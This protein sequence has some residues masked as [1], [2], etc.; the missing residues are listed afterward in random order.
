MTSMDKYVELVRAADIALAPES[1]H[2]ERVERRRSRRS[3]RADAT[4]DS[5]AV[6]EVMDGIVERRAR[7]WIDGDGQFQRRVSYAHRPWT[8]PSRQLSEADLPVGLFDGFSL[9]R[10]FDSP[11]D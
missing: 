9:P 2:A 11:L 6:A 8:G 10:S 4:F 1:A 3:R 7:S 5:L